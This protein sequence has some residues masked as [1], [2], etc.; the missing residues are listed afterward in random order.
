MK[1]GNIFFAFKNGVTLP[2]NSAGYCM[3]IGKST[4]D[5]ASV[6]MT[7][8]TAGTAIYGASQ[9]NTLGITG[10]SYGKQMQFSA[11]NTAPTINANNA[12]VIPSIPRV[13]TNRTLSTVVAEQTLDFLQCR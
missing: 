4:T 5:F 13:L 8:T 10:G 9:N 7:S 12:I 6:Q 11:D 1:H 3:G 2:T